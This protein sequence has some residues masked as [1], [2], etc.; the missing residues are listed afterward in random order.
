MNER[1]TEKLSVIEEA[2][3]AVIE[4]SNNY[5]MVSWKW[6]KIENKVMEAMNAIAYL[7]HKKINKEAGE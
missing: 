5:G 7:R 4:N 6:A 3:N 1:V 2:L